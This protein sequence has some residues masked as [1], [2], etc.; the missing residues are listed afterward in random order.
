[1]QGQGSLND[2]P[3][4]PQPFPTGSN[5]VQHL[6]KWDFIPRVT[7]SLLTSELVSHWQLAVL[8]SAG[9]YRLVEKHFPG[10]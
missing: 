5:A 9:E 2:L 4:I 6:G 7:L 10:Y 8:R 1:M 3:Y